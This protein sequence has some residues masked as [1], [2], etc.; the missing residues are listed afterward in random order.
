MGNPNYVGGRALPRVGGGIAFEEHMGQ[1]AMFIARKIL[2]TVPTAVQGG[3]FPKFK[4]T[5]ILRPGVVKRASGANYTR[6][7]IDVTDDSFLCQERGH[8]ALI[9]DDA[10][11]V[12]ANDFDLMSRAAKECA[13]KILL[14]M[15]IDVAAAIQDPVTNWPS[16]DAALYTDRSAAPWDTASSDVILHVIAAK[17]KVRRLTG[18]VPD[19]L[20]LAESQF[21]NL[22]TNTGIKNQFPGAPIITEAMLQASISQI[23]GLKQILRGMAV[24]NTAQEGDATP[25]IVDVWNDDYA[26]VAYIGDAGLMSP[27]LGKT[28]VFTPDSAEEVTVES[29]REEKKRSE[30][31]RA[32]LH[33]DEKIVDTRFGHLL[34]ID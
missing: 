5:S 21:Q 12:V 23:F 17:E 1:G 6:S 24:K 22:L 20:I 11:A 26:L 10:R 15:E 14:D 28:M 33:T 7:V 8:E 9:P 29:Y 34:K 25:D 13:D 27:G 2:P 3:Y 18:Y 31:V 32:R 4:R 19:T 30:V 16:G